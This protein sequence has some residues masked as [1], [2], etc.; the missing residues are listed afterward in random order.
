[1]TI[2]GISGGCGGTGVEQTQASAARSRFRTVNDAASN[3][4]GLSADELR[5]KLANGQSLAQVAEA[6]GKSADGLTQAIADA[7]TKTDGSA[8]ATAI[9]ERIVSASPGAR[10]SGGPPPSGSSFGA[11]LAQATRGSGGSSGASGFEDIRSAVNDFLG[12]TDDEVRSQLDQGQTL[13]EIAEASGK[14]ADD[15]EQAIA[16]AISNGDSSADAAGI[17]HTIVSTQPRSGVSSADG[18]HGPNFSQRLQ[19]YGASGG[20]GSAA[21]LVAQAGGLG[22]NTLDQLLLEKLSTAIG[23]AFRGID[24]FA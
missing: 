11:E 15:L 3:Y 2:N 17:A 19:G 23:G 16:K 4:L 18:I 20:D 1:M 7:I 21:G 13:G 24:E 9:A 10:P 22:G 5:G 8:N 12:L 6:S 14:T